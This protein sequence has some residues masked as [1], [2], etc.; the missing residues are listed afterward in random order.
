LLV[1]AESSG[2]GSDSLDFG[3]DFLG[4][5]FSGFGSDSPVSFDI[6]VMVRNENPKPYWIADVVHDY[7]S[8][9]A[10]A[11]SQIHSKVVVVP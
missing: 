11:M 10:L 4:F 9:Q 8:L 5:D 6:P 7:Y 3:F 2:S 1:H